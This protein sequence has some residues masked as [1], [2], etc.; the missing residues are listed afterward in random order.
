MQQVIK[1]RNKI[2]KYCFTTRPFLLPLMRL[3]AHG[4]PAIANGGLLP[5]LPLELLGPDPGVADRPDVGVGNAGD[6]EG[7]VIAGQ[8][9]R[10]VEGWV[11]FQVTSGS[12]FWNKMMGHVRKKI[13]Q[14]YNRRRFYS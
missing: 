4:D 3:A 13:L 9:D 5:L 6:E 1:V 7:V 12:E 10:S 11:Q 14:K 8:T 2:R